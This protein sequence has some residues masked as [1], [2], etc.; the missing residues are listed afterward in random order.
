M[1]I[2]T[3][4]SLDHPVSAQ[5]NRPGNPESEL[6]G[7]TKVY[8]KLELRPLLRSGAGDREIEQAILDAVARKPARHEFR[9]APAKLMRFMSM[10]GG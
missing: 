8:D 6:A 7:G 1:P 3:L 9:E 4:R 2:G 10:T 5:Q